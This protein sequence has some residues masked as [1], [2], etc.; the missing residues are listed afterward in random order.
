[1]A[2]GN[3]GLWSL[4]MP[5]EHLGT[6]VHPNMFSLATAHQAFDAEGHIA[7]PILA[8]RFEDNLIAFM[9]L[10]EAATHYP[11]M[12]QAWVEFLGEK[13]TPL[14]S[15][16]SNSTILGENAHHKKIKALYGVLLV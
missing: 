6:N 16:W 7:D 14:Q 8:K 3:R 2:G 9:D 12:K 13:V 5:L 1:M 4:R 11:C 10:V 15:G